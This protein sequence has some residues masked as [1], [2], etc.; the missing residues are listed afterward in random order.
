MLQ[1]EVS[2][3][4]A[5]ALGRRGQVNCNN[6]YVGNYLPTRYTEILTLKVDIL[7]VID[8]LGILYIIHMND[9]YFYYLGA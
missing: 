8:I 3:G 7:L 1:L 6:T 2:L 9:S 4:K 5:I